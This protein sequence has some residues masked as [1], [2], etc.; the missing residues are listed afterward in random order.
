[1]A[2]A[3]GDREQVKRLGRRAMKTTAYLVF[4]MMAGLMAVGEPLIRWLLTDK[5]LPCVPYLRLSCL[6]WTCQPI[7]TTNWQ[8]IKAMGRSDLCFKLEIVKKIIGVSMILAAVPYGVYAMGVSNAVFAVVSMLINIA[9]NKKLIGYS[10]LEQLMDLLPSLLASC[11]MGIAVL[12]I[13]RLPLADLPLL[14]LQILAGVLLYIALSLIT[15]NDSFLYL[16][17]TVRSVLRKKR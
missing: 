10:Y 9:P 13:G 14:I 8:V 12:L 17:N 16:L 2:Q 7:Q 1:M 11:V 6:Y 15:R 3:G 4:P 5:W